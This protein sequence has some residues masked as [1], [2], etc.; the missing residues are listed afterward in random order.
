MTGHRSAGVVV[1]GLVAAALLAG[2]SADDVDGT[3]TPAPS[4]GTAPGTSTEPSITTRPSDSTVP[5][6]PLPSLDPTLPPPSGGLPIPIPSDPV[7]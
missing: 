7:N 5:Q 1:T 4:S 6:L 2:C 3:P